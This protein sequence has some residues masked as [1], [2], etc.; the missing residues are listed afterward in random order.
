[1]AGTNLSDVQTFG[2]LQRQ[3]SNDVQY[4]EHF[5][6]ACMN[7]IDLDPTV[8]YD[9]ENFLI[10]LNFVIN[11]SYA[12]INDGD[13]LPI[14]E[15]SKGVYASYASKQMY[16]SLESTM[17][18]ATRGYRGGR[19]DGQWLDKI[20]RDT[21]INCEH[22]ISNDHYQNG[23]GHR[24]FTA[25]AVAGQASFTVV[26]STQLL[27]GMKLDWYNAAM[28]VK[29][30]TIRIADAGIDRQA[31]TVYID[32]SFGTGVVPV[33]VANGDRLIIMGAAD[34]G[35]PADGRHIGGLARI[36]DN[37]VAIG[38]LLAST[39]RAWSA[40]TENAGNLPASIEL[41]QRVFDN[42]KTI[43]GKKMNRWILHSGQK[44]Q[45]FNMLIS[46]MRLA[47]GNV[48]GGA[49]SLTFSPTRF[50]TDMDGDQDY[51]IGDMR[52]LEDDACPA[53]I[54]YMF[55]DGALKRAEDYTTGGPQMAEED[56]KTFRFRPG[57]DSL[58][59]FIRYWSNIV[60]Y[61]RNAIATIT[62]LS[63]PTGII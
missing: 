39:W 19:P 43:S 12:A 13:N 50:G 60:V 48:E 59:A 3:Y 31:R 15:K 11:T 37:S 26:S 49:R 36:T 58:T 7:F 42:T 45:Y 27:P 51:G 17:K 8:N 23:R 38:G 2:Q 62:N 28:A 30:G 44:R 34:A 52:I 56:G 16:S 35:E 1:M 21:L 41:L 29:L 61:Q 57:T 25:T 24:A 40:Y 33:G 47:S 32:P 20:V 10:P 63:T 9:G 6:N 54:M 22:E 4:M 46:Q 5:R 53:N 14:A 18:A 55:N